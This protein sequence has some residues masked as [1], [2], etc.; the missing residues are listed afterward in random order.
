MNAHE[1]AAEMRRLQETKSLPTEYSFFRATVEY[2]YDKI[3][4]CLPA[5]QRKILERSPVVALAVTDVDALID[6]IPEIPGEAILIFSYRLFTFLRLV[7]N[8][9]LWFATKSNLA[10]I[11]SLTQLGRLFSEMFAYMASH[12]QIGVLPHF[13]VNEP[14]GS[15]AMVG[16]AASFVS[17]VLGHEMGHLLQANG[18]KDILN[19][20]Y[21]LRI[22]HP[23]IENTMQLEELASDQFGLRCV[24][25]VLSDGKQPFGL[26]AAT[27]P[28]TAIAYD[29]ALQLLLN[30]GEGLIRYRQAAESALRV[31][32]FASDFVKRSHTLSSYPL[33]D[34]RMKALSSLV[35][36][37]TPRESILGELFLK[38]T[39]HALWHSNDVSYLTSDFIRKTQIGAW[40]DDQFRDV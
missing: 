21:R 23:S 2:C 5:G 24:R 15:S 12:R 33:G 4:A 13:V 14:L 31:E 22:V 6:P 8:A 17:F 25:Y 35:T 9:G 7:Q 36:E 26:T 32:Q 10:D 38:M 27:G 16:C 29:S 18:E 39:V 3:I 40:L 19:V 20:L 30:L 11:E 37:F 34:V 1:R 28:F